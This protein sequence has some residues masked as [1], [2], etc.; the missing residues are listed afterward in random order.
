MNISIVLPYA[1]VSSSVH[2]WA[3]EETQIDFL[4]DEE[5]AARCTLAFAAEELKAYL[6]KTLSEAIISICSVPDG[7]KIIFLEIEEETAKAGEYS[8]ILED[9]GLTIRGRGRNGLLYGVYDFLRLQGWRWYAPGKEGEIA[10]LPA[11]A[12]VIPD[13]DQVRTP[14]MVLGRGFHLPWVSKQSADLWIWM[15]RNRMNVVPYRAETGPLGQK[16]GMTFR[17]GGHIFENILDP[18]RVL[19][20]GRKL[21]D[22][23]PDW[24]GMPA[25]GEKQRENAQK[26]QFCVS[27]PALLE[28]LGKELIARLATDWVNADQI[29]IWG[30]DTW[31]STC[32]C[33]ECRTLGN[34]SDH[35]L[36]LL[37][38]LRSAIDEA[39]EKGILDHNVKLIVCA[40]EGTCTIGGPQ[41]EI[42]SNLLRAGDMVGFYP[43]LRCYDHDFFDATCDRNCRYS[44]SL[45]GWMGRKDALPM[46]IGEYYNVSKFVDLPVMLT[47]RI[48]ADIPAYYQRGVRAMTYMHPPLSNWGLRTLTQLLYAALI[49]DVTTDTEALK[50]EYFDNWY[51]EYADAAREIYARTEEAWQYCADWRAWNVNSVLTSLLRWDGTPPETQVEYNNHLKNDA[52]AADSGK[53][54]LKLME[55][56]LDQLFRVR[57]S[58]LCRSAE[59]KQQ[60]SRAV[61]PEELERERTGDP[62]ELRIG[63]DIRGIT[64]GRD[65]MRIMTALVGYREALRRN[66]KTEADHLWKEVAETAD[67][68]EGYV[69]PMDYQKPGPGLFCKDAL[70]RSQVGGVLTRCRAYRLV[71]GYEI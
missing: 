44:E 45:A 31:G 46:I 13:K 6:Q 19:P 40:Y 61:N 7:D 55:S 24:F 38:A 43:I 62:R 49:W 33:E 69:V 47:Q 28:F 66:A 23:H 54:S 58:L 12:L 39:V 9:Y 68:L 37:S 14:S 29:D 8:W 67:I 63:E 56:T 26:T 41:H 30:F 34:G 1:E 21:W 15:A 18:E 2:V 53:K 10:P 71:E 70:A 51:G 27:S 4:H 32:S 64:Y 25:S 20:G 22:V 35:A 57:Q 50:N 59:Q 11:D 42:P 16:L 3:H 5:K 60:I 36:H 52:L 65:V 17:N 48:R